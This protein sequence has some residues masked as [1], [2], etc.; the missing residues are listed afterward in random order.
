MLKA[1][2]ANRVVRIPDEKKA[3]Y[4][5]LGYKI[6]DMEDNV[7]YDPAS[8]SD[9]IKALKEAI[10]KKD[11]EIEKLRSEIKALKEKEANDAAPAK[12]TAKAS[13]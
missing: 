1:T 12:K 8:N 4:I 6:L 13:K 7:I 11:A 2:R 9:D 3:D 10:V 5:A